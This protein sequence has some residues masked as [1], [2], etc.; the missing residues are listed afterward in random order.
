MESPTTKMQN[1]Q[2]SKLAAYFE[3]T[4]PGIVLYVAITAGVGAFV[5][6]RSS[7]Q[8]WLAFHTILGTGITTA[9][10]LAL[11]QY[12]ERDADGVMMRTKGRPIPS[13]RLSARSALYF[14]QALLVSGLGYLAFT[15]SW[16]PAMIAAFSALMYQAVY[17]PLKSRSYGA[18][19][20]GG[21]PGA[22]P[23]LIGWSAA[24]GM[25]EPAGFALFGIT[26]LWQL[27]HVLALAWILRED[28]RLVGFKLIPRGGGRV[29]WMHM[30]T[31]TAALLPT[32]V[33]L[34][35]LG[36]TWGWYLTGALMATT[37]FLVVTIFAA[38]NMTSAAARKVFH[39]SLLYHPILLGLMLFDT[40]SL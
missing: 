1:P 14:S 24:T 28:Y 13:G 25:L 29:I 35:I 16:L 30:V 23:T 22:L 19:L 5:G 31:A 32:V 33:S 26:Y 4:K 39:T 6:S 18:T 20:A 12:T 11:N 38:R 40:I 17:T 37:Y 34:N 7:L 10:A 2:P 21:V 3:L 27:P 8:I 15:V 9:G 36:Y